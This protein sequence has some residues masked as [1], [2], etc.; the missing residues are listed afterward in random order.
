MSKENR[1]GETPFFNQCHEYY[2]RYSDQYIDPAEVEVAASH[3]DRYW[4]A[5]QLA[6]YQEFLHML[7]GMGK[8]EL[9]GS[10]YKPKGLLRAFSEWYV[11]PD[12]TIQLKAGTVEEKLASQYH[13]DEKYKFPTG[14]YYV[15]NLRGI[16]DGKVVV[17]VER[18][19]EDAYPEIFLVDEANQLFLRA[20]RKNDIFLAREQEY[21]K[22]MVRAI[23]EGRV[24]RLN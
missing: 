11:S 22:R 2:R 8:F 16:L 24:P 17:E 3:L 10:V 5:G 7:A 15:R 14:L 20:I 21:G 19:Y 12:A 1:G 18:D 13:I 6:E 23:A 4:Q 9:I